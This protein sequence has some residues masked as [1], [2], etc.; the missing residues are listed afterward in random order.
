MIKAKLSNG[1]L[2]LGLSAKDIEKLMEGRPIRFDAR[3]FDYNGDIII[4]YG[5]TEQA[6][7]DELEAHMRK[8]TLELTDEPGWTGAFTRNDAKQ[9]KYRVG[10]RVTKIEQEPGDATP[11]GTKGTVLGSM[12][13]PNVGVGYFVEWDD[14]PKVAVLVIERRISA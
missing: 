14:K 4:G 2:F 12:Y 7:K 6:I 11:V 3:M 1:T 5:V 8:D 13:G 10:T 9:A